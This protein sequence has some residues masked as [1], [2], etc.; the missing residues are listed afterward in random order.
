V[1]RARWAEFPTSKKLC[2]EKIV[3]VQNTRRNE[4]LDLGECLLGNAESWNAGM[5]AADERRSTPM[6]NK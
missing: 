2:V 4:W 3:F 5:E 6:E 1:A